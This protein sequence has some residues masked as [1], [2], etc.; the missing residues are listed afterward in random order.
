[1]QNMITIIYIYFMNIYIYIYIND[2]AVMNNSYEEYF[3]Y[4]VGNFAF[5]VKFS[6]TLS[7]VY[8]ANFK[9]Y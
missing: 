6:F 1:M 9:W 2:F 3:Y 5:C 8:I 4:F 7:V